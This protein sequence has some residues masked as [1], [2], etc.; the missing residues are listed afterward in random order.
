MLTPNRCETMSAVC[1]CPLPGSASCPTAASPKMRGPQALASLSC[2]PLCNRTFPCQMCIYS[3]HC[4]APSG[5]WTLPL[6][7]A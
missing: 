4:I 2:S 3:H 7:S 6:P 1:G 5:L